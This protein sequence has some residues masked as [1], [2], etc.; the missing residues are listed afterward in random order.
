M[1]RIFNRNFLIVG[2]VIFILLFSNNIIFAES[3]KVKLGHLAPIDDP[4]H[5]ALQ[6][7]AEIVEKKTGDRIKITIYPS[8]TLGSE[9]ELFEQ[10]QAGVTEF[11]L[12]GSVVGNFVPQ[13]AVMDFP[14][15]W[16]NQNHLRKVIKGSIGREWE[17]EMD[18]K[19]NV[20][21]LAFF[22]RNP[23]LLV[24]R[25]RPIVKIEDLRGL[26]VRVPEIKIYI[27][28][29]RAF[30]VQPVSMP[31]SEFY[32]G[33][34]MGVIDAMEN[35][36]EVMYH[37]KIYEVAKYLSLTEHVRSCLY[38]IYSGKFL[39]GLSQNDQQII[40]DAAL[41]GE[42]LHNEMI[43]HQEKDLFKKLE[44]KGMVINQVDK[45]AFIEAAKSVH[46]KYLGII[47]EDT[48]N[49]ILEIE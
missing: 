29:W 33:L 17:K 35:P 24:N 18:N 9:R 22:D 32:M 13:W 19:Y 26:K 31:A 36:V 47:G 27:D 11:A 14:Y 3:I 42:Q 4:R 40:R 25:K 39:K 6:K 5:K 30:G 7:F 21:I 28:T 45:K 49:K 23:R 20:G 10:A 43:R 48:Y 34:K 44:E 46:K 2:T 1:E 38:F 16:K 41:E 37:W 12:I 8:S 15:L